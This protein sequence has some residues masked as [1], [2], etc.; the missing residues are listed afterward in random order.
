VWSSDGKYIYMNFHDATT[1]WDG[2]IGEIEVRT[3]KFRR[4]TNDLNNYFRSLA[5]TK[6][7]KQLI[8]VQ[9]QPEIGLY[10]MPAVPNA[11]GQD[12]P[13][14][15]YCPSVG[16]LRNGRLLTYDWEEHHI[17]SM[18]AD[19]SDRNV[20]LQ[21]D[22][23]IANINICPNSDRVLFD[24]PN[25]QSEG[26]NIFRMDVASGELAALTN[27]KYDWMQACSPDG[28]F[29]IYTTQGEFKPLVMRMD[30][31]GGEPKKLSDESAVF[32]AISPDSQQV[33]LISFQGWGV[34]AHGVIK[35][36]PAT[37]GAA[38]KSFPEAEGM[39]VIS[40]GL[41]YAPDGK[42]VYYSVTE[43]GVSNLMKQSLDGGP[44]TRATDFK[45]LEIYGYSFNWPANKLAI[46]RGKGKYDVVV[47][48]QQ[49]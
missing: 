1:R 47:I 42:A 6:N 38:V 24:M 10:V 19:G 27:G 41:A 34:Q 8:T 17:V 26:S 7:G 21:T 33:A 39:E 3:G 36:I 11:A 29:F 14:A 2:Q 31:S 32:A 30:I 18:N 25:L 20:V 46:T 4:I 35:V 37:G 22:Q 5:V 45:E 13:I 23:P 40:G 48:T 16:W 15:T 12:P 28:T 43:K 49:P 9:S 44:P